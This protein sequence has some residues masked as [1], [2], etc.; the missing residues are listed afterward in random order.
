M[1]IPI[2]AAN[3]DYTQEIFMHELKVLSLCKS[4]ERTVS[5][6]LRKNA[7]FSNLPDMEFSDMQLDLII[8]RLLILLKMKLP[9]YVVHP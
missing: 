5:W 2:P 6:R 7:L 9:K 3:K 1:I 4:V 8:V